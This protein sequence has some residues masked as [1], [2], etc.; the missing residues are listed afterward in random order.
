MVELE[1]YLHFMEHDACRENN[2][3]TSTTKAYQLDGEYG[4]AKELGFHSSGFSKADYFKQEKEKVYFIELTNL[5]EDIKEC[6]SC[7]KELKDSA[8]VRQYIKEANK[9]GLKSVQKKLWMEIITEFKGKW[10]GSIALYERFL[11]ITSSPLDKP[12]YHLIVVLKNDTDSK[13]RD[14][15]QITLRQKLSGMIPNIDVYLTKELEV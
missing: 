12:T 4:L 1:K 9:N 5:K 14:L 13:D 10:M 11:R 3:E 6:I 15:L 2:V 8:L 7:D